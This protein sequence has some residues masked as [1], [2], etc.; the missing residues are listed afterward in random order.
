[1][2]NRPLPVELRE[3][4]VEIG[5]NTE[6]LK[7]FSDSVVRTDQLLRDTSGIDR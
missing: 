6:G 7:P 5:L 2:L 3:K 4:A 1:M